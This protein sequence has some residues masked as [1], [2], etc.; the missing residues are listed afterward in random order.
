MTQRP[1]RIVAALSCLL[2]LTTECAW[3]L[4]SY[5]GDS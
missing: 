4:W 1:P 3:V 5:G 2:A